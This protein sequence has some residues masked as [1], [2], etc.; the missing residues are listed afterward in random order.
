MIG[1][2]LMFVKSLFSSRKEEEGKD[3]SINLPRIAVTTSI[4][5]EVI[6]MVRRSTSEVYRRI[7]DD[8]V[9]SIA[10]E[11]GEEVE[12]DRYGIRIDCIENYH[13]RITGTNPSTYSLATESLIHSVFTLRSTI[14]CKRKATI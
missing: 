12:V 10:Y 11:L 5:D 6:H 4:G 7:V 1:K 14:P 3:W 8:M 2:I 9:S 13:S